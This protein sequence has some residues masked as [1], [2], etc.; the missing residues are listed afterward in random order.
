MYYMYYTVLNVY[1]CIY[2]YLY[3]TCIH[4]LYRHA[5]GDVKQ[6][7]SETVQLVEELTQQQMTNLVGRERGREGGRGREVMLSFRSTKR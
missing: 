7:N 5:F 1:T 3:I 2:V 4:V 6:C